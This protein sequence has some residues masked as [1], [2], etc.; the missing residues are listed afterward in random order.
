MK[1]TALLLWVGVLL[2]TGAS[3]ATASEAD[4]Q[5]IR[6]QTK[7]FCDAMVEGDLSVLDQ[8]FDLSEENVFYDINEGPLTPAR[9][10]RV[11]TA[12]TTNYDIQRFVFTDMTIRVEGDR[13]LQ[14]GSWEQTQA[15]RSGET[16]DIAGRATIL[17][18]KS[19]SGWRVYHYHASVTPARRTPR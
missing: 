17:W 19:P 14:T 16:R 18:K 13:A 7:R 4:E 10:K 9:L 6:D 8:I 12:A 15:S 2:G 11:W 5:E 1:R 3:S